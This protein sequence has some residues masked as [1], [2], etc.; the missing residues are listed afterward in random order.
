M[1]Q[2]DAFSYAIWLT[3][4][5]ANGGTPTHYYDRPMRMR[6]ML[7]ATSNVRLGGECGAAARHIIVPDGY[8]WNGQL[9][10]NK[11]F[12]MDGYQHV[13][14]IVPVY[15]DPVFHTVAGKWI[16]QQKSR[17]SQYDTYQRAKRRGIAYEEAL[18]EVLAGTRTTFSYREY[19]SQGSPMRGLMSRDGV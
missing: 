10:H 1:M 17:P 18:D 7:I 9:G 15:N 11:L 4:F 19:R 12:L 3:G 5:I 2:A 14:G 6:D 13:G 8:T 16:Q